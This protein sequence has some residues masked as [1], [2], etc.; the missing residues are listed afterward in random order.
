MILCKR[1]CE[2]PNGIAIDYVN[3]RKV[4]CYARKPNSRE[5]CICNCVKERPANRPDFGE[6]EQPS[7]DQ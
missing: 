7:T 3:G 4:T 2:A 1:A 6:G 5:R